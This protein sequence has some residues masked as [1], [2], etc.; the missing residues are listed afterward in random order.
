MKAILA[1]VGL[2]AVFVVLLVAGCC[3]L[4]AHDSDLIKMH[5]PDDTEHFPKG[6]DDV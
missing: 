5:P 4:A 1:L 2:L 3:A 6:D